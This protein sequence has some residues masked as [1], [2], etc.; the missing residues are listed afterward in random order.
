MHYYTISYVADDKR[1]KRDDTEESHDIDVSDSGLYVRK[2][3][4]VGIYF[5]NS[6]NPLPVIGKKNSGA[7][8]VCY[9]QGLDTTLELNCTSDF[10]E[11]NLVIFAEAQIG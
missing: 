1:K 6:N 5:E 4:F 3:S 2:G 8:S 11:T 10:I 9:K 7:F